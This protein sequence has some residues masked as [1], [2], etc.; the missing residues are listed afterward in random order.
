MTKSRRFRSLPELNSKDAA[1][2]E[3][4][5]DAV[6][7]IKKVSDHAGFDFLSYLISL[8]RTE[9]LEILNYNAPA[10]RD[11]SVRDQVWASKIWPRIQRR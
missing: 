3:Y 5:L 10:R 4:L 8:S 7:D 11:L 9:I 2:L 1:R 6:T